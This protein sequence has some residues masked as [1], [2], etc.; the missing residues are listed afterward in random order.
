MATGSIAP[1]FHQGSRSEV[2]A[3][4]LFSSWGTV[5][6]VRR[7]D[8]YG[9]DLFCTL[10]ERIGQ[11]AFVTDYFSVQVKSTDDPWIMEGR[12]S[13]RWLI[14]QPTPVFLACVDKRAGVLSLYKTLPRFLAGFWD[15]PERLELVLSKDN[16]GQASQ[17]QDPSRFELSAPILRVTLADM[18]NDETMAHLQTVLQFWVHVD[19]DNCAFRGMGLLR[20]REPPSYRVNEIPNSG[21]QEQGM[22]RPS[23]AQLRLAVLHL[24][25]VV[26]CVG[27]QLLHG[28]DKKAGL[29]ATLLLN[30]LRTARPELLAEQPRWR[31]DLPWGLERSLAAKLH[32]IV[33]AGQEIAYTLHG[34]NDLI[35]QV[36]AIGGVAKFIA[37]NPPPAPTS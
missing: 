22:S 18:M 7:T 3:D 4:Y 32:D 37:E 27:D 36:T 13:V 33:Y 20:L 10:T 14:E 21:I 5:T 9:V 12:D 17:W 19:R 2:L 35:R 34:L 11:R 30:H 16:E 26:D 28:A 23:A 15:L 6:P 25:E 31:T 24:V 29:Y 8:D 1:N